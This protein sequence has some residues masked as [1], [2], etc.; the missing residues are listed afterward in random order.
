MDFLWSSSC[1]LCTAHHTP[2]FL[3]NPLCTQCHCVHSVPSTSQPFL[4]IHHV[5]AAPPFRCWLW[6][7]I[8]PTTSRHRYMLPWFSSDKIRLYYCLRSGLKTVPP[9]WYFGTSP[10]HCLGCSKN[11]LLKPILC[12][13][14][15]FFCWGWVHPVS[16]CISYLL[17][18]SLLLFQE[19]LKPHHQSLLCQSNMF[20]QPKPDWSA[21]LC[22]QCQFLL[23]QS[24]LIQLVEVPLQRRWSPLLTM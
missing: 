19:R 4:Q 23:L 17:T 22:H 15:K 1:F 12:Y 18:W 2:F 20:L 5:N 6:T 24:N 7:L 16:R 14:G 8:I 11:H 21:F 10:W 3:L 9:L 13:V